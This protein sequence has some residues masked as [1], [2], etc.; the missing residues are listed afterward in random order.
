M[1]PTSAD[2]C[3]PGRPTGPRRTPSDL[4][5]NTGRKSQ[6]IVTSAPSRRRS[7][8]GARARS[9]G[10]ENHACPPTIVQCVSRDRLR[11]RRDPTSL[12]HGRGGRRRWTPARSCWFRDKNNRMSVYAHLNAP[13]GTAHN[14][15]M[16]FVVIPLLIRKRKIRADSQQRCMPRQLLLPGGC[17]GCVPLC[18]SPLSSARMPIGAE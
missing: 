7:W 18:C 3:E 6:R 4:G 14:Q 10:T 17:L 1:R 2:A 5:R 9:E 11:R 12:R 16:C 13:E 8:D 15:M